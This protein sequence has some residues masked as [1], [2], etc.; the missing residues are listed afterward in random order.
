MSD[1]P[2]PQSEKTPEPEAPKDA[3]PAKRR[4]RPGWRRRWALRI[5]LASLLL[6]LIPVVLA[7]HYTR[8]NNLRPLMEKLL[9]EELGG[10]VSMAKANLSWGGLLTLEHLWVDVP[11]LPKE[12]D[13]FA[14]LFETERLAVQLNFSRLW[15]GELRV[16]DI[17][18]DRPQLHIIEDLDTGE[19]NLEMFQLGDDDDDGP[20]GFNLTL[21]P[22]INLNAARVRFAQVQAGEFKTIEAIRLK[23]ELRENPNQDSLFDFELLQYDNEA[24]VDAKLTGSL[25]TD[26]PSLNLNLDGFRIDASHRQLV[27]AGFRTL[28]DQLQPTGKLP[29]LSIHMDANEQGR[30][31]L[32]EAILELDNVAITPPYEELG[33]APSPPEQGMPYNP[34]MTEVSG[35]FIVRRDSVRVEDFTGN[36]EGIRYYASGTWGFD[37]ESKGM[38]A[39]ST[40]PFTLDEDPKF[41]ASLPMVGVRIFERLRPSGKFQ[42]ST[43]FER[44][45]GESVEVSGVI[46]LLQARGMYHKFPF[47]IHN[48]RGVITFD[49]DTVRID[50]LSGDGPNGGTVTINGEISPPADGA[51]V[52]IAVEA[53]GVP[54]DDAIKNAFS[55]KRR[56]GVEMF[57][58]PEMYAALVEEQVIRPSPKDDEAGD[59][60]PVDIAAIEVDP[61]LP[62]VFDMGGPVDVDVLVDRAFGPDSKYTTTV[63]IDA[64]GVSALFR[65][66][67]Y[68]LTGKSGTIVV[69]PGGITLNE[70]V[71]ESP[72]GGVGTLNGK[73]GQES[74]NA[75]MIPDLVISD[76]D[77]PIDKLLLHSIRTEQRQTVI[78]LFPEG[79]LTGRSTVT[80]PDPEGDTQWRVFADVVNGTLR[81]FDGDYRLSAVAGKFELGN[82]GLTL[83]N[84]TGQRGDARL[85]ITGHFDWGRDEDDFRLDIVGSNLRVEPALLDLLPPDEPIREKLVTL[86]ENH[87]P[88]GSVGAELRWEKLDH[89]SPDAETDKTYVLT[90]EPDRF[91]MDFKGDRL[92]FSD[93]AG[94]LTVRPGTIDVDQLSAEFSTGT[95]EFNG[96]IGLDGITPT[97]L[98]LAATAD[99]HCP[100]TRKFLPAAA[101]DVLNGLEV[102][103]DYR[104]SD[105]RLLHRPA[106]QPGQTS[107][108]LDARIDLIDTNLQLGVPLTHLQGKLDARI[109][110]FP[111]QSKPLMA[112]DLYADE[113]RASERR[114]APLTVNLANTPQDTGHLRFD[115]MLGGVYGGI[116]VGA[117]SIP[118]DK[119]G[120][121]RFDLTLSDVEV[122]PFLK[123]A[124]ADPTHPDSPTVLSAKSAAANDTPPDRDLSPVPFSA[125]DRDLST[126]LLS[127]SLTIEAPLSDATARRGRG[128]LLITDARLIDKPLS[129]A[130]LRASNLTLPS[131][132]PLESASARYLVEGHT[133]RFDELSLAG[134]SLTIAGAGTMKLPETD[135]NLVMVSRNT[136]A[137]RLGPVS[138]LVN[139]FKDELLAIRVTGTLESP[140]TNVTSLGGL[141]R[142]WQDLFGGLGA[143]IDTRDNLVDE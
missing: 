22:A 103:G 46:K 35:R 13:E 120:S 3:A 117:G 92:E 84:L 114:I 36:I 19:L 137:P 16:E 129:T 139:L 59:T 125:M 119:E 107:L 101:V 55:E 78:D 109:R 89:V 121:Y 48:M 58:D 110:Q 102:T 127:A 24:R 29:S 140:Q 18:I 83:N 41:L 53:R 63:S 27:P 38:I 126:G 80:R 12:R 116:L 128:A 61:E 88:A 54:F 57:F 118:L 25:N 87:N 33:R 2:P 39:V 81:P 1:A 141:Q 135:L 7:V 76:A 90:V 42:A 130:L 17:Q 136:A 99:T 44:K 106:P 49:R 32:D 37:P 5:I 73:I 50:N 23:G 34:R 20:D 21:P 132:A 30:L 131:G 138:D 70:L 95:T 15:R 65:H 115:P 105:A 52:R 124:I 93:M 26:T 97:A 100:Y 69:G 10:D 75:P 43:K 74:K 28:W 40:D 85:G 72:T 60:E 86:Q 133:V 91:G 4:P 123:P 56:K 143:T 134:P 6:A 47:P 62:P 79:R 71:M 68:P 104:L 94:T 9:S 98:T 96:L 66:W 142:G 11:N 122:E 113:L 8:P 108:E 64:R 67:P 45:P 31:Q 112:F 77:L 82:Y 14:K 51:A 111:G